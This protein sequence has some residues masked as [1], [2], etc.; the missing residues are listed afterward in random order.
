MHMKGFLLLLI[1]IA[2]FAAVDDY[3]TQ[4]T[5]WREEMEQRLKAEDGW[6][7]VS[8]LHWLQPGD[9]R[10]GAHSSNGIVLPSE[11]SPALAG[12]FRYDGNRVQ[13]IPMPDVALIVGDMPVLNGTLVKDDS[14]GKP[15]DAIK[16]RDVT[17]LVIKR[18]DR[19]GVRVKDKNAKIRRDFTHRNWFPVNSNYKVEATYKPYAKPLARRIPTVLDGVV[20]DHEA[21][22]V[23]EFTL[24]GE[25]LALEAL[26]SDTQ[27]F[28]VFRDKTAN[29]QTYGAAR[30]LYAP[31]PKT[32]ST[33]TLDFNKAYN[34]PCAFNPWTTCPLPVKQNILPIAVEAGELKYDH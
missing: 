9:T 12:I 11:S 22:G 33:I 8:G 10:F 24:N 30:F 28:F 26:K 15:S 29:K 17:M 19:I 4:I 34:P 3:T 32:G 18:G 25:K 6:L 14:D 7:T 1:G 23:A 21:I 31:V 5:K 16:L 20:E 2:A 27:L 13:V